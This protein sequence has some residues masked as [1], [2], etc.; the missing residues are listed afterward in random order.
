MGWLWSSH[1]LSSFSSFSP[2]QYSW[3]HHFG[4]ILFEEFKVGE[5]LLKYCTWSR[6]KNSFTPFF[7]FEELKYTLCY[8]LPWN[9]SLLCPSLQTS[10]FSCAWKY[11]L[12]QIT[13]KKCL[14][15]GVLTGDLYFRSSYFSSDWRMYSEKEDAQ[16]SPNSI[17]VT[18]SYTPVHP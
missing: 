4:I 17:H 12:P 1:I 16:A 18:S 5:I 3:G 11:C 10:A 8:F 13:S 6:G 2:Y 9:L 7:C 14:T 15:R